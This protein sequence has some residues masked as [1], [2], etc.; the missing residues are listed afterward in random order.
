MRPGDSDK[1]VLSVMDNGVGIKEDD[2]DNLYKLFGCLQTTRNMNTQGIGLGLVIS[3][4]ISEE[5]D[6]Q[7]RF[8]SKYKTG[9]IFQSSFKIPQEKNVPSE[10]VNS[11]QGLAP[12][13]TGPHQDYK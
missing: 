1:I 4:M 5:F 10:Q 9:S 6:G 7:T 3:K 8:F 2:K 12:R 13:E 11:A